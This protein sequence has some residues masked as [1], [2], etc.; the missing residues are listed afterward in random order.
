[1]TTVIWWARRDLRLHDN[2]A[3]KAALAHGGRVVPLFV[4]DPALLAA[5]D[6]SQA[7]VAFLLGGL[8]DLDADLQARGSRLVLRRGEPLAELGRLVAE[9]GAEAIYAEADPWPYGRRRDTAV[10]AALPLR[11]TP[12][13]TVHPVDLVRKAD[14]SP[15]TVFTPFSRA[16]MARL[17]SSGPGSPS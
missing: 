8:R 9:T 6:V 2:D 1:M 13:L 3:L 16:W 11:L 10:A 7:R 15:Y 5:A 17:A 4:L 12:G 14:G